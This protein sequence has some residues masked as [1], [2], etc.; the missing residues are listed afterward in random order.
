[1]NINL[2]LED[3]SNLVQTEEISHIDTMN[4]DEFRPLIL[5]YL[6]NQNISDVRYKI[7]VN[8]NFQTSK[9]TIDIVFE[10]DT[11]LLREFKLKKLFD[12]D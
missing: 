11:L 10:K 4:L 7:S 5:K 3:K 12:N 1:M 6:S 8:K 2:Y 9:T